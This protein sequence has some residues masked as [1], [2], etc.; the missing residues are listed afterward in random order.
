MAENRFTDPAA[1]YFTGMSTEPITAPPP[2]DQLAL[3]TTLELIRIKLN[4]LLPSLGQA[5]MADS[6]PVVLASNQTPLPI[7]GIVTAVIPNPLP[8]SQSGSWDI[9]DITGVV[10]LPTGAST[11][12]TLALIKAKTDNIDVA[13][14]TRTKPSDQQHVIVDSGVVIPNPLPV[15]QSGSWSVTANA[16][17]NLNTSAL[18][19]DATFTA[20]IN[21][22]GQ[23][24]MA[25]S[26]P[27]VIASDQSAIPIS[28]SVVA[29]VPNP[30]P[31]SQSGNW[32][33][34]TLDGAGNAITS[35]ASALDVNIKSGVTLTV[36]LDYTTDTVTVY[37]SEGVPLQQK[38]T[39]ND[40]IVTLDGE[41]VPASQSGTWNITNISGTI[42]LPTGASTEATLA[43]IKAKTDNIP[44][45]GQ[46]LAAASVPVVL[47]AAQ[48][49]TLTPLST[50]AATQSGSWTVTAN[51]GTNLNTSALLLDATFTARINTLG[52]K[53]MA[54]STPVVIAS[55]QSAIPISGTVTATIPNPLPVSQSGTWNITNISGTISLPIGAS[56][57]ATLALIKAKTDNIPPLGQALAAAS[58]PVVLTAAQLSTLT[59]LSTI[60]A[61]QSG[62]WTVT[63]NAGT[64]LNTS[65]LL[66][67]ATFTAR[68]NTLGQ[69]AMAASTPV[70]IASDQS[71]IPISGTVTATI[72][73]PLPVS[74]SGTWNITNI[75]GTVS[76]PT[77]ASTLAEQVSQTT[78]LSNI[79]VTVFNIAT[80]VGN[81]F[82]AL[83]PPFLVAVGDGSGLNPA[84]TSNTSSGLGAAWGLIVRT[85]GIVQIGDS[86]G[87]FV[88]VQNA[89]N[90]IGTGIQAAGIIAQF[91]DVAPT[92][93]TENQ[94]GNLRM[95]AN[96]VL[97][98]TIRDAAGNERGANVNALNQ[99]SVSVDASVSHAVTNA[100][101]FVV[102]E[103][104]A[105]LT[106]LQL[107]DNI[108]SGSG[109]NISQIN[110]VTPLMGSGATGTGSLRVTSATD[111]PEVTALQI[112]DD[113][114]ESDRAKVNIIAGQVGVQGGAGAS[115]ALTQRMAIATD[116]NIVAI[117]GGLTQANTPTENN[118][119]M[120]VIDT[121]YSYA[122]PAGTKT[123]QFQCRQGRD[124]RFAFTTGKVATSVSPYQ[125]LKANNTYY[126]D[127][128]SLTSK[129]IYFATSA[130]AGDVVEVLTWQ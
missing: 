41:V 38:V 84:A 107:I 11:E 52:Q 90:S 99:L 19:L 77:G 46:A 98:N 106:A 118:T 36:S 93:V 104:G 55:D 108:V 63:A 103:N 10:S 44:P 67:D 26:T 39:T 105:A 121:E 120:V 35:T 113:W 22:L 76:L 57:E 27:V 130:N 111:S 110:G 68:I 100:G 49:S 14:S 40:L 72:P 94:F 6:I 128:L 71:A 119:P 33:T 7:S 87:G 62:A 96:G 69:K 53:V 21:T 25:A 86:N 56:T 43:L 42:A 4:T 24:A 70:V 101:T 114:D 34:R 122:I 109:V 8:V 58:V 20:R 48:L 65:A 17:T 5:L 129:I 2:S 28:G 116:A 91:D 92:T 83:S 97:Y 59:P 126:Q 82:T 78:L 79:D 54:S 85:A 15:S 30:L 73:N 16:G 13:L 61:T 123:L 125:T 3:E 102:Q 31:V 112:M 60:A 1:R 115:T 66:L 75:S 32:S 117:T 9:Q 23:K 127:F 95:S 64:N 124:M 12:A 80:D 88:K 47:T 37:G 29:T 74:Q 89:T 45:L 81:I 50:V 51:A 18:F